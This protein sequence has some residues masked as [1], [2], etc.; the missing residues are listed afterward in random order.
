M[1][2]ARELSH[3]GPAASPAACTLDQAEAYCRRL[4]RTHYENFTVASRLVPRHLIQPLCN[5]YAYCR[6]ADDLADEWPGDE[7]ARAVLSREASAARPS[8]TAPSRQALALALLDWW[9]GQLDALYRG[10]VPR[11]PVFLALRRTVEEFALPRQPLA[12][13]LEAMR[14]DQVQHRYATFA[15]LLSYCERSANPVGRLVLH[16]AGPPDPR[17][18]HWS[19]CLCTGLQLANFC[20]DVR[21]DWERGRIYLPQE[22]CLRHGWDETRFAAG[23]CDDGFRRLLAAMVERAEACFAEG[24]PLTEQAAPALRLSVRLCVAGGRAILAAIRR[25]GYDVWSGRPTLGRLEQG[26]LVARTLLCWT[27][28]AA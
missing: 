24:R 19:D 18:V 27:L 23:R 26:W 13:L 16:L 1:D 17:Q 9:E 15:D 7:L 4:A 5:L 2:L 6:W 28:S 3:Y 14:R 21:R 12:D 25:Q 11:H 8:Q 22:E 20:Q 10:E